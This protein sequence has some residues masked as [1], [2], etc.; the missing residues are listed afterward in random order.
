MSDRPARP[1]LRIAVSERP[2]RARTITRQHKPAARHPIGT[3]RTFSPNTGALAAAAWLLDR[4][5]LP[6]QERWFVEVDLAAAGKAGRETRFVLEVYSEEW[7]FQ[8]HH[9]GQTSWIRVTDVPFVHGRDDHAMLARMPRLREIGL[10][11][12]ELERRFGVHFDRDA[13]GI[14]TSIPNAEPVLRA[15]VGAL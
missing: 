14:R 5:L 11:V 1:S 8:V 7:G 6:D 10:F 9:L 15:W 4:G 13:A 3:P 12:R 2:A